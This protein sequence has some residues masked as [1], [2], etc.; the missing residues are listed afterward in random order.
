M[1]ELLLFIAGLG[2]QYNEEDKTCLNNLRF[3]L[4]SY[5]RNFTT[6]MVRWII[7]TKSILDENKPT[8]IDSSIFINSRDEEHYFHRQILAHISGSGI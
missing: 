5:T 2:L 3:L 4:R 6:F 8:F 7:I 1:V